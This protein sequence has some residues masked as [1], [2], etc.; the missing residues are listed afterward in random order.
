MGGPP[1][2]DLGARAA[3]LPQQAGVYLFKD[4]AGLVLYVGKASNLRSRVRQY[5]AGTDGRFMVPFLVAQSSD[6]D[7][8]L[9]DSEKEALILENTLIKRHQPPYNVK[10][11]DDK[12]FLHL[13]LDPRKTWPRYELVRNIRDDGARYFGPYSSA[14][15]ARRTLGF[16]QRAFPLRT[17]SDRVLAS[18]R[19]PCV[20]HQMERCVAPCVAGH[21]DTEAY[22]ELVSESMLWLEGRR[23]EVVE[24]LRSRMMERAEALQ[25]EQ[26]ARLRDLIAEIELTLQRQKMVDRSLADRDVMGLYREGDAGML[27]ILPVR[28]GM[29]LEPR[30]V[31]FDA[32]RGESAELLSSWLNALYDEDIPP[33]ILLPELP[34]S[35]E[36]LVE[37]LSERRGSRVRL[38]VPQRGDKN[39]LMSL[40]TD[41][42]R[43][44]FRRRSDGLARRRRALSSL[45]EI[46]EL[47]APPHRVECFD[48]S[49]LMGT[50]P[51]ASCV[52]F[53]DG[54][55]AKSEYRHYKIKTV[56]GPDDYASMEEILTRRFR[57]AAEEG[58][59]PDLLVVDGGRGQLS[60]AR[61]A[62]RELGFDEQPVI[63]LAKPRT[64][65][66]RGER[67]AVDK[68][69]TTSG[70]TVLLE[71]N[72]PALNLLRHLRDEAHRF[73]IQ[74][75]RRTRRKDTLRSELEGL[76][77]IGPARR[78]ALVRHFGSVKRLK[79]ATAQELAQVEGIGPSL[80]GRLHAALG[81]PQ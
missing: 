5:L 48:N 20:L 11:R 18:R 36:V 10:L 21:T 3:R 19:R 26:A 49:N 15:K 47:P 61:R 66:A 58:L 17:C 2:E 22:G 34:A 72:D 37:V 31:S 56:V 12:N 63:G 64:E 59:F 55:P 53:L 8:V 23:G 43:D 69:I 24:R 9:T 35:A 78:K 68:I 44:R 46:L 28:R 51:V 52:V 75:H 81:G 77:G 57:R 1:T 62:L 6:V 7:V 32:D 70:K 76:P 71:D 41:N 65:R 79:T 14:S 80:A 25:F 29:M 27:A 73:A 30:F 74:F 67:D 42:A 13:R 60:A 38:H 54:A 40:A 50:N 39:R 4:A 16:L 45:A 33:E